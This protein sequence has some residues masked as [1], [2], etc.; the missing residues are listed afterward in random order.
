M[1]RA[2]F[3][4]VCTH[5]NLIDT[6]FF[7]LEYADSTS[8]YWL[9]FQKHINRQIDP[10]N[11][12]ILRFCVKFYTPDPAQLEDEFTRY[13]FTLQIKR[14]LNEGHLKC[15][16]PTMA[17]MLSYLVQSEFGD[18]QPEMEYNHNQFVI[19]NHKKHMGQSPAE[20]DLNLLETARR[21][22]LYG[23]KMHP[24]K[25]NEGVGLNL[26]V[27]HLGLVVFQQIMKINTFSWA[28]IRKLSFKRK[29][30]LI[31]LHTEGYVSILILS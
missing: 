28:K 18:W 12:V 13:L 8:Y 4:D 14:D 31:K 2:L 15:S 3:D 27:A 16:E 22:E 6:D 5:L 17:L 11:P 23:I 26:A 30:F 1:G 24:C 25:D 19:N 9:D 10:T 29:R 7:G 21:C 20:A